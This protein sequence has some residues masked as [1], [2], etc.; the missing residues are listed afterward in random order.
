MNDTIAAL[1]KRLNG[2]A[3]DFKYEDVDDVEGV[4]HFRL[5]TDDTEQSY[6]HP[7]SAV[8]VR[9]GIVQEFDIRV[10]QHSVE[11]VQDAVSGITA[12]IPH[13]GVMEGH[14]HDAPTHIRAYNIEAEVDAL[15]KFLRGLVRELENQ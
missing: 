4:L 12:R 1:E 7:S 5:A 11:T 2:V 13:N 3:E 14:G 9:H 15:A 6:N 8:F 10:G